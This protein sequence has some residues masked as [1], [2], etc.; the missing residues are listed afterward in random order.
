VLKEKDADG[1]GE[2]SFQ[3]YVG[4]R[5]EGKDKEWIISEKERFDN[6]LDKNEDN[7]LGT[8]EILAWIIPS[9]EEIATDEVDHL[10]SG[11]DEDGDEQLSFEEVISNHD[12]FVGSEAT[13]YGD[14][15]HNLHKYASWR[16]V[17]EII[18]VFHQVRGRAVKR[19]HIT[20][21]VIVDQS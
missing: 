3:E 12:L 5:G 14:H 2:L 9:N 10:F 19:L 18:I 4:A 20:H 11:A 7:S 21:T 15:L 16:N 8:E 6:D 17:W 13:D 1:N